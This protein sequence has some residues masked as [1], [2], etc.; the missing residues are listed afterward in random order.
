M[1]EQEPT[2]MFE[3]IQSKFE[4]AMERENLTDTGESR[5]ETLQTI[6]R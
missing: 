6:G 2:P 5:N 3:A 1:K 4:D